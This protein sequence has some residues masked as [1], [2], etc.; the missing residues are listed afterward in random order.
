M[1]SY[2][3]TDIFFDHTL[4]QGVG[5]YWCPALGDHDVY[6]RMDSFGDG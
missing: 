2:L 4:G 6:K 3:K 1:F 5:V